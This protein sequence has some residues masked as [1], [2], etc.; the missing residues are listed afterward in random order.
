VHCCNQTRAPEGMAENSR[1]LGSRISSHSFRAEV[2]EISYDR[3]FAP[4]AL[5]KI[6]GPLVVRKP[7]HLFQVGPLEIS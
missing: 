7:V 4:E 2:Q 3:D 5:A 1:S 6:P